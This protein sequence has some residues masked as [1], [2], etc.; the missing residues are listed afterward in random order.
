TDLH[1]DSEPAWSPDGTKIAFTSN[2]DG[3]TEIFVMNADGSGQ[4]QLTHNDLTLLGAVIQFEVGH[5]EEPAWSPDGTKIAFISDRPPANRFQLFTMNADGSG[6]AALGAAAAQMR[7]PSW[8]PGGTRIAVA[9]G[10]F[11]G[12]GIYLAS[13]ATGALTSLANAVT[14]DTAPAFSPDGTKIVYRSTFNPNGTGL[15]TMDADG[16]GIARLTLGKDYDPDWQPCATCAPPVPKA[17]PAGTTG[18]TGGGTITSPT[19]TTASVPPRTGGTVNGKPTDNP[20]T[21]FKDP[22]ANGSP[23]ADTA[24]AKA[25]RVRV[26]PSRILPGDVLSVAVNVAGIDTNEKVHLLGITTRGLGR[27]AARSRT[28]LRRWLFDRYGD[29]RPVAIVTDPKVAADGKGRLQVYVER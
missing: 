16:T 6:Q 12:D 1:S 4:T 11:A 17:P 14:W 7:G 5:D 25:H 9:T 15:Y 3:D 27:C 20:L 21:V 28:A 26:T 2:R 24:S 23:V 10:G 8:A 19:G 13:A 22:L 29:G 18:N